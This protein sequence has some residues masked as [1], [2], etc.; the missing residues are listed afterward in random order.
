MT[1]Y[2]VDSTEKAEEITVALREYFTGE[3][4]SRMAFDGHAR[5]VRF[6]CPKKLT[7]EQMFIVETITGQKYS[8]RPSGT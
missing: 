7:P 5:L 8:E 3:Q 2:L 6:W 4:M 1:F